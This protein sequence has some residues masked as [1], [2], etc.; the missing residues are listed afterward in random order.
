ME[1]NWKDFKNGKIGVYCD[2]EE[3]AK[4][5]IK[6]CYKHGIHWYNLNDN[7]T[8]WKENIYYAYDHYHLYYNLYY[9]NSNLPVV[10]YKEEAK[11]N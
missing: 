3:E 7:K 10:D 2:T 6:E 8:Y 1:F 11:W 9:K 5:F 4:K